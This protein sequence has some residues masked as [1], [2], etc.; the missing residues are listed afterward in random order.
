MGR[1]P[2]KMPIR[3]QVPH[4]NLDRLAF[5]LHWSHSVVVQS[6]DARESVRRVD[7]LARA[8]VESQAKRFAIGHDDEGW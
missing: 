5:G 4:A 3:R 6:G 7:G 2:G 8:N 1:Q